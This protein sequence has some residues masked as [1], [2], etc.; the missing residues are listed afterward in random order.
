MMGSKARVL[1]IVICLILAS[2]MLTHVL[3]YMVGGAIFV[4]ALATCGGLSEWFP[5]EMTRNALG[6]QG[7]YFCGGTNVS[8]RRIIGSDCIS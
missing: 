6:C 8:R 4:V 7:F 5:K 1:F 3:T 2:L